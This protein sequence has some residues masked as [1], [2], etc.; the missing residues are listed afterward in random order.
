MSR[1]WVGPEDSFEG[2]ISKSEPMEPLTADATNDSSTKKKKTHKQLT[3]KKTREVRR[4][5]WRLRRRPNGKWPAVPRER[6][7]I[8]YASAENEDEEFW[9]RSNVIRQTDVLRQLFIQRLETV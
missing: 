1:V 2:K 5:V 4:A 9:R 3:K 6:A 8:Q 7:P